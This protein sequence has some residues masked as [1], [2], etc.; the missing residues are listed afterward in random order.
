[1]NVQLNNL[2]HEYL[3]PIAKN[4]KGSQD[5][6]ST[7]EVLNKIDNLNR[8]H[9]EKPSKENQEMIM[10]GADVIGLYANLDTQST[11]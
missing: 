8:L 1:M 10:I 6:G 4:L 3:Q 11:A 2:V 9:G 7:D 5:V